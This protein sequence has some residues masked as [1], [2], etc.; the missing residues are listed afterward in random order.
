MVSPWKELEAPARS[1]DQPCQPHQRRQTLRFSS[2][3]VIGLAGGMKS[4]AQGHAPAPKAPPPYPPQS[5]FP[6]QAFL[7]TPPPS[8]S[9]QAQRGGQA[10]RALWEGSGRKAWWRAWRRVR[11]A[12]WQWLVEARVARA[13]MTAGKL[14]TSISQLR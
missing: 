8:S 2:S 3:T 6:A 1:L 13:R 11:C 5:P 12:A 9:A 14:G 7:R 4:G 10:R